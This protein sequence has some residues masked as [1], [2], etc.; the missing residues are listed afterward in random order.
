MTPLSW[1]SLGD[2][3]VFLG[4]NKTSVSE[5][6]SQVTTALA[7]SPARQSSFA[8]CP[9]A[10]RAVEDAMMPCAPPAWMMWLAHAES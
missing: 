1:P 6:G 5:L 7:A 2:G 8:R 9:R 10:V 4:Q 3:G